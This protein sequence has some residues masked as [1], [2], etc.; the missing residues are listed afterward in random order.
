MEEAATSAPA[1]DFSRLWSLE[2]LSRRW[3]VGAKQARR[4]VEA[5]GLRPVPMGHRTVR[6][7]PAA[8]L[9]AEEDAERRGARTSDRKA[10]IFRMKY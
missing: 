9:R 2:D 6:Y 7:R 4:I 3:G 10:G 8:V 5:W 1:D